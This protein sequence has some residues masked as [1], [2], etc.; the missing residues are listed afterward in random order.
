MNEKQPKKF[1]I[2]LRYVITA[3]IAII[4]MLAIQAGNKAYL[5]HRFPRD[6]SP[7]K[8]LTDNRADLENTPEIPQSNLSNDEK[9]ILLA[10]LVID[11]NRKLPLMVDSFTRADPVKSLG[12]NRLVFKTTLIQDSKDDIDLVKFKDMINQIR[13]NT[14]NLFRTSPQMEMFRNL[15]TTVTYM[16]CDKDSIFINAMII[17][18]A[19]YK[20]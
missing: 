20:N 18:P 14:I 3:G 19:D 9:D 6:N 16:W 4:A 15:E 8:E 2:T 5:A 10:G 11:L 17:R 13:P 12:G 7:K 1:K